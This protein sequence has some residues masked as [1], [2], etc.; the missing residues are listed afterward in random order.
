MPMTNYTD[1]LVD[2]LHDIHHFTHQNLKMAND[3]MKAYFM[4]SWPTQLVSKKVTKS[5]T[6]TLPRR[7]ESHP[8]CSQVGKAHTI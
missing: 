5:G 6:T 2:Q 8:S 3:C 4:T 1:N 7:Q